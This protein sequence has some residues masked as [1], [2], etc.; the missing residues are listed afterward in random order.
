MIVITLTEQL[1]HVH[2]KLQPGTR[3]FVD[4]ST[5]NGWWVKHP[6]M[7]DYKMFV[8]RRHAT[9]LTAADLIEAPTP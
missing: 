7:D 9:E 6:Q 2:G 4:R 8:M 3:L 5:E 1:D